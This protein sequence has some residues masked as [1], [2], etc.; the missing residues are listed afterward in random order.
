M[1]TLA[2]SNT[3]L[4]QERRSYARFVRRVD[5]LRQF[6]GAVTALG[7]LSTTFKVA[8]DATGM[9]AVNDKFVFPLLSLTVEYTVT[10]ISYDGGADETSITDI[11]S[12]FN[13]V[14]G[15]VGTF[16]AKVILVGDGDVERLMSMSAIRS[17]R[18]GETLNI[19]L[20]ADVELEFDNG[21]GFFANSTDTG[22]LDNTDIFWCRVFVGY[23]G[24]T[25]RILRFAGIL[26]REGLDDNRYEKT[27]GCVFYGHLKE[28]ERFPAFLLSE[29][30]GSFLKL[31]GVKIEQ[32]TA[33]ANT[34]EG[35]KKLKWSFKSGD[36]KGVEILKVSGLNSFG[37]ATL[38]FRFPDLLKFNFGEW[39]QVSANTDSATLTGGD[40]STL[41]VR[42]SNYDVRD[43]SIFLHIPEDFAPKVTARGRFELTFDNGAAVKVAPEFVAVIVDDAGVFQDV[44]NANDRPGE[45]YPALA[46]S[47]DFLYL[48]FDEPLFA[49]DIVLDSSSLNASVGI[50]YS[51]GFNSWTA[52]SNVTDTTSN[53]TQ[54]GR[55]SWTPADVEGWR[56]T[57]VNYSDPLINDVDNKY[58][59]KIKL[60]GY[61]SGSVS[62]RQVRRLLSAFAA[63][64]TQMD[65]TVDVPRL[66]GESITEQVVV[67]TTGG[68]LTA[69]A[70]FRNLTLQNLV[71]KIFTEAK[72]GAGA[73]LVEDLKISSAQGQIHILGT[74]PA[75]FYDKIPKALVKHTDGTI[76][77]GV[78]DELWKVTEQGEFTFIAALPEIYESNTGRIPLSIRRLAVDSAGQIQG[79]AWWDG[80][81]GA[82]RTDADLTSSF[83][84]VFFESDGSKFTFIKK[85]GGEQQPESPQLYIHPCEETLRKGS[86]TNGFNGF[87]QSPDGLVAG[88]QPSTAFGENLSLP[89]AQILRRFD[90][91]GNL[92]QETENN[93]FLAD[94][95]GLFTHTPSHP[96]FFFGAPL[97]FGSLGI[98]IERKGSGTFFRAETGLYHVA[99]NSMV[100]NDGSDGSAFDTG[101]ID[102]RWRLGQPGVMVFE[103]ASITWICFQMQRFSANKADNVVK[104]VKNSA[105]PVVVGEVFSVVDSLNQPMS[106]F[107][108]GTDFY[109]SFMRW[110]DVGTSVSEPVIAKLDLSVGPPASWSA[111]WDTATATAGPGETISGR[112][113]KNTVLEMTLNTSEN[114]IHGC[115]FDRE[116]FEY[117][118]F[119]YD[120]T[121]AAMYSTQTGSGFTFDKHRQIKDFTY[122]NGKIYSVVIDRRYK[123]DSAFL[124]EASFS[125]GT[126]TLASKGII[127]DGDTDHNALIAS[128]TELWGLTS[129]GV[130]WKFGTEFFPRVSF[131]DFGDKD[132][133]Q[134]LQDAAQVLNRTVQARA[135]RSLRIMKRGT[136][137]GTFTVDGDT[138]LL[139]MRPLRVWPFFYDRVEVSWKDPVS[140]ES[141]VESQG[142]TGF[143]RRVLKID[144]PLIQNRH[145]AAAVALEQFT[146]F[147]VQRQ[148]AES[149][150]IPIIELEEGDAVS[151][152][153][154]TSNTDVARADVFE[155]LSLDLDTEEMTMTVRGL[156]A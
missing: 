63:D 125:G 114:T 59:L 155:M 90:N 69:G 75:P 121:G 17:T 57:S 144:N 4:Q 116:N 61:V 97:L 21:D 33:S 113:K 122:L 89:F 145:L 60:T 72:Y 94:A 150:I 126:I 8:G 154:K 149:D 98:L 56:P 18:Q 26:D 106:G 115:M 43:D 139:E 93:Y 95:A 128:G 48:F 99:D 42:T 135:D 83:Y 20:A 47:V 96:E 49:L 34:V 143:E 2:D 28:L 70:W 7:V 133:R 129:K 81:D 78:G 45:I 136:L 39:T 85:S 35:V 65:F 119:V 74:A 108:N 71:N 30:G 12:N 105:R 137:D 29:A 87:G 64:G 67:R 153:L 110:K 104:F 84:V 156:N 107:L 123:K 62:F 138:H 134:V 22:M 15:L 146:Y 100:T 1:K 76:Y 24:A 27:F 6:S 140:G 120:L 40:G 130:L 11:N 68:A 141:G 53:L 124:L 86:H 44:S 13:N 55:M 5:L 77:L 92:D 112:E 151:Y 46:S 38:R 118:Y 16:V 51:Q 82:Q 127:S 9:L 73:T 23:K 54:D 66:P 152:R 88:S 19:W 142:Q 101:W 79:V 3:T 41:E 36:L 148:A 147:N 58:G 109:Y 14:T 80:Y 32:L 132:L 131:A 25:D 52:V 10:S 111:V 102:L 103:P 37:T 31:R 91:F 50:D 117:H